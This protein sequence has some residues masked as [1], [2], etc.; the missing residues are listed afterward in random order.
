MDTPLIHRVLVNQLKELDVAGKTPIMVHASLRRIGPIDGG[1][2]ALIDSLLEA[3]GPDGTLVMP[4]GAEEDSPFDAL[5]S[6]AE[7]D[8]GTLAEVFR[9]R[10][11]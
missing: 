8:I 9:N 6:R 1:A 3:Q 2:D 11:T 10:R 4:L 7:K 5:T